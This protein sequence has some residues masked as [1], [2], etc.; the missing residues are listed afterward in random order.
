MKKHY[1][2]VLQPQSKLNNLKVLT[3]KTL[4]NS[5]ISHDESVL[6]NKNI[7]KQTKKYKIQSL[8]NL[9]KDFNLFIKQF[10]HFVGSVEKIQKVKIL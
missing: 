1:K 8:Q 6:V 7:L 2:I 10:H 5:P 4:I 3:S 9:I